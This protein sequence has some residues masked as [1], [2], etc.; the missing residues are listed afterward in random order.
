MR[1]V[2]LSLLQNDL[3]FLAVHGRAQVNPV[4]KD[5]LHATGAVQ[6][7][8]G[9][10]C[11]FAVREW[12]NATLPA[13]DERD[14]VRRTLLR[15]PLYRL[16]VD[17]M[18]ASVLQK[19]G[20]TA[21]WARFEQLLTGTLMPFAPRLV[22]LME[23]QSMLKQKPPYELDL[24]DW[25]RTD[26]YDL[27]LFAKW[28]EW[29]WGDCGDAAKMFPLL[30]ALYIP[31]IGLPVF[32]PSESDA[33]CNG[34]LAGL[35]EAARQ[36]EGIR[37]MESEAGLLCL[38]QTGVP[39][40][41]RQTQQNGNI[42]FLVGAITVGS[43]AAPAFTPEDCGNDIPEHARQSSRMHTDREGGEVSVFQLSDGKPCVA[44]LDVD[45]RSRAWP[46]K[47]E[48]ASPENL[49]LP[50]LS[51][52]RA[53][54][55]TQRQEQG[56]E[57]DLETLSRHALYGFLLQVLLLEALDRELGEESLLIA[58]RENAEFEDSA[59]EIRILYRT[60]AGAEGPMERREMVELGALDPVMNAIAKRLGLEKVYMSYRTGEGA[61]SFALRL[62]R[63]ADMVQG[64]PERWTLAEHI[65]DRLH[66]G[67]LMTRVIRR[68]HEFR[69]CLHVALTELH[70][71][72]L[73]GTEQ[74]TAAH[75]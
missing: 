31:L 50:T 10:T 34:L 47:W 44:F 57:A 24:A 75:E 7:A 58:S 60:R 13:E 67:G 62:M 37:I 5:W 22:A 17:G 4:H 64:G 61:W 46:E 69:E 2:D 6:S 28:D 73:A 38:A 19:I 39:L 18:V 8:P 15:D 36:G 11:C 12:L 74:E 55:K 32:F 51:A 9:T 66:A 26:V 68:G 40:R 35:A 3:H 49:A 63:T 71:C 70:E 29:N 33:A 30:E 56:M 45:V 25:Q 53:L 27:P 16:Y 65:L 41:L 21:R 48:G 72:R 23:W 1:P 54:V 52:L 20:A 59:P 14:L 42:A 43:D